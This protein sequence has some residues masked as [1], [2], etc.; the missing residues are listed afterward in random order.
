MN[1]ILILLGVLFLVTGC[2]SKRYTKK[3]T[4]FEEAGLYEDAA[5][6]Y[7]EAIKK[8]DSNIDAKL[9]LRKNGQ[10][11]LDNKLMI[12]NNAYKQSDY[13]DAVYA[14]LDAESYLNKV[15]EVGVNL[16]FAEI[17]KAYYSEAKEEYFEVRYAE[18]I[19][20]LNREDF[21]NAR[22][23]FEEIIGIDENYKDAG[24]KFIIAKY[25]PMYRE[26]LHFLDMELYRKA[27]YT[28]DEILDGAGQY[29]QVISLK[30]EALNKGTITILVSDFTYTK[31]NERSVAIAVNSK[32]KGGLSSSENPFL[33]IVDPASI[34][35]VI[36]E[37]E[38]LNM[39]AA[40]L[41]GIM[42]VLSCNIL[43]IASI[44]GELKKT[45]KKGYVKEVTKMQNE[46]GEEYEKVNYHK[47]E[48]HE[49]KITNKS[50]LDLSFKLVS[51]ENGEIMITDALYLAN[52]D[53]AHYAIYKGNKKKL[54]PGYWKY[55][56]LSSQDD[57]IN[58]NKSD[59]RKLKKL[60]DAEQS[61][62]TTSI[63]INELMA[64]ASDQILE[65]IETYNPEEK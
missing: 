12:F 64:N 53:E 43:D 19:E 27:Y 44:P 56:V 8:K 28:F 41:A 35:V 24:E 57:V 37:N 1:K 29:K 48:Y 36:Y 46:A 25:E 65:Q 33:K 7:Y 16:E 2:A 51:T 49:Y 4:K 13:K 59:V 58:D 42:A 3:A 40:N 54:I 5:D 6:Y 50:R 55:K 11:V 38:E 22:V 32:I 63:L 30:E 31:H 20:N 26:G 21:N 17:N 18:G 9:G 10:L 62:K 34:N 23:I 45:R 39:E 14:F 60:L 61:V 15:R 52:S 47:T